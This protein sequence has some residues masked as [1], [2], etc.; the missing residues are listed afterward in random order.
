MIVLLEKFNTTSVPT[1]TMKKEMH[2][3]IIIMI[4]KIFKY[5]NAVPGSMIQLVAE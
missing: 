1:V 5:K 2:I 3:I 4:C